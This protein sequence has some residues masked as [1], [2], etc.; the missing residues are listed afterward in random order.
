MLSFCHTNSV[1]KLDHQTH[2]YG[3]SSFTTLLL[4]HRVLFPAKET[5]FEKLQAPSTRRQQ[6]EK[7]KQRVLRSFATST[8]DL[9][10]MKGR[11]KSCIPTIQ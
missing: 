10:G 3:N 7:H 11:Q 5:H 4:D 8:E 2:I 9:Q 6:E 1:A